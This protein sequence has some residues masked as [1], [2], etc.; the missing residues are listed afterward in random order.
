M[1]TARP[2]VCAPTNRSFFRPSATGRMARSAVLLSGSQ[3]CWRRQGIAPDLY[4]SGGTL[5]RAMMSDPCSGVPV[6]RNMLSGRVP[7]PPVPPPRDLP[8]QIWTSRQWRRDPGSCPEHE[9]ACHRRQA[10]VFVR[11][12]PVQRRAGGVRRP[13]VRFLPRRFDFSI[14]PSYWCA[15]RWLWICWIVSI[16]T[17]TT[18]NTDVPPK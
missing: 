15:S 6:L 4:R 8:T 18:I 2:S 10:L 7:F 11:R 17:E 9:H 1:A 13:P 14:R 3:N 5:P 16:V 12:D